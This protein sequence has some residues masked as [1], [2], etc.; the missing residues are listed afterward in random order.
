MAGIWEH[1]CNTAASHIENQNCSYVIYEFLKA[2]FEK[3]SSSNI[4]SYFHLSEYVKCT[5]HKEQ[6]VNVQTQEIVLSLLLLM[7]AKVTSRVGLFATPRVDYII[8]EI[9][10]G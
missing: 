2:S 3:E 8:H 9:F 4:L 6:V 7:K 10:Q 5:I 1:T